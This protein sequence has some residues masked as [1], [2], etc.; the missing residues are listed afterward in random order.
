[1]FTGEWEPYELRGSRAI[2]QEAEAE[3]SRSTYPQNLTAAAHSRL[4]WS[5]FKMMDFWS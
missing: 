4:D 5:S 1:M 3:M 2:L